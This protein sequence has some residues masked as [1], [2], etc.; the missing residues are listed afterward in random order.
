MA[1]S[2]DR[3]A[4][5]VTVG[6]AMTSS[7]LKKMNSIISDIHSVSNSISIQASLCQ[8]QKDKQEYIAA[9]TERKLQSEWREKQSV[10]NYC[11]DHSLP[12]LICS[13]C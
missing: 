9:R 13:D 12:V 8:G 4:A 2:I 6:R 11:E 5:V 10:S 1:F 3:R 7:A